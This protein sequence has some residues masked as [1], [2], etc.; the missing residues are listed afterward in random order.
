MKKK[1]YCKNKI[2]GEITYRND[3]RKCNKVIKIIQKNYP[4]LKA[5]FGLEIAPIKIHL[6]YS[7]SE[8]NRH[9][10]LKLLS[11]CVGLLKERLRFTY[12]AP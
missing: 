9:W 7:R 6:L 10:A 5:F 8:I 1:I 3:D 12:Q 11:G 2:I 4:R